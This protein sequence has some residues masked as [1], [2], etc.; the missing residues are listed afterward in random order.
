[1][2]NSTFDDEAMQAEYDFSQGV[3]GKHAQGMQQGYTVVVHKLDGTTEERAF[4]LPQG[5]VALD[6]DVQAYF[7]DSEAVNRALRGLIQLVPYRKHS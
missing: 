6:A 4:L 3:R 5:V 7:P 2:A 1:M